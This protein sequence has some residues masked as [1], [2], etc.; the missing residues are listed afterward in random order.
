MNDLAQRISKL[1]PQQRERLLKK[2]D[3]QVEP[4]AAR[5]TPQALTGPVPLSFAQERL[6]FLQQ[7]E[8][9]NTFYNII[10]ALCLDGA[11]DRAAL[12]AAFEEI[13]RRHDALRTTFPADG[14][15]PWQHIAPPGP[16]AIPLV[17]LSGLP[18]E[19]REAEV[20]RW[21]R[22]EAD[23]PFKLAEEPLVRI[24]LFYLGG[25]THVLLLN[26][27][28]I[29]FDGW[30]IGVLIE[31]FTA[32][33][34]AFRAGRPSPLP[35]LPIQ[36]ADYSVWQRGHLSGATLAGHLDYWRRQLHG[37]P[38]LLTLPT[39]RPRPA[40]QSYRGGTHFFQ[41]PKA[42]AEPLY[43]LCR[44]E[45]ATLFMLLLAAFQLLLSRH[46]GQSDICVG[47]PIANRSR[48][49]LEGLI[50]FFVNTMVLRTDLSGN[51]T[52]TELLG[53]VR[54]VCLGAQVH[55]DL[56]FEKLV[57]ELS[58]VRD[59]GH[60][61]LFQAVLVL[62]NAPSRELE[63]AG[64]R[65]QGL[66]AETQTAKFDL[67]LVLREGEKGLD[68]V[69]ETG[70]AL[71]AAIEYAT[72]L[73]DPPTVARL[74][75]HFQNL[76]AG[77]AARPEARLSELPM[78]AESER[79]QL[80]EE[81][82]PPAPAFPEGPCLHALFEAQAARTPQAVALV[83]GEESLTY[84][85]LNARAN[86]LAWRLRALG[87][88]PESLVGLCAERS[89][90][91]VA[92]L[93][94]ILKAGGAYLPLDPDYPPERLAFMLDDARPR[95]L[96]AHSALA[97]R[98]PPHPRTLP[99]DG[100]WP[101][102]SA[103]NPP[104]LAAPGNLAYVIYTSGSTGRPK[105]VGVTH[106]NVRRLFSATEAACRFSADDVWT[107]FHS[108]AFDFS[109]WE[110]WGALLYG[111]RA[112]V[113]PYWASRSPEA[114]RRLLHEQ[115]VTVFSQ[116]PSSFYQVD[117]ADAERAGSAPL[118]LKRVVFGGEALDAR[119]LAGWFARHGAGGPE[120]VNM[121]G[122]TETTVHVT[123]QSLGPDGP[124]G[125]IGRPLADLQTH[126]LDSRGGLVPVGVAGEICVG[127]AGLARGYLNRPGL[128]AERFVPDPFGPPGGRLYR[129]GDLARRRPDGGLYYLGRIDH[130]V[131]IRG[132]RIELGE[133]EARLREHPGVKDA[134]VLAGEGQGGDAR[135]VAYLVPAL[136]EGPALEAAASL[137]GEQ[138]AQW[139]TVF[140]EAFG[141]QAAA[142]EDPTFRIVGW[143]SSYTS[144]PFPP[145]EMREWVEATVT[146]IAAF[147]PRRLLEIGCGM[148][149][150][151]FRLAPLVRGVHRHRLFRL[152]AGP[153]QKRLGRSPVRDSASDAA[154]TA[155]RRFFRLRRGRLR[156]RGVELR[157]PV[158]PRPGLFPVGAAR[159]DPSHRAGRPDRRRRRAQPGFGEAVPCRRRMGRR[160]RRTEPP[161]GA[162]AREPAL[163]ARGGA[164]AASAV[165]RLAGA[166]LPQSQPRRGAAEAWRLRQRDEPV[167]LRRRD[168]CR[169]GR[170]GAGRRT[171][172]GLGRA[173]RQR[174]GFASAPFRGAA[175]AV[176]AQ[177]RA[178]CEAGRRR[179]RRA[180][181]GPR[182]RLGPALGGGLAAGRRGRA[183]GGHLAAGGVLAVPLRVELAARRGG[184]RL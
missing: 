67:Q 174:G 50:G 164:A 150:L 119:R 36:Y 181:A 43:E 24:H 60:N 184:R 118:A 159:R 78:L 103:A 2:L 27:H 44:R 123:W 65:L 80:L 40:V 170:R 146:R 62:Q 145:E 161:R 177:G 68:F 87:V 165:V 54:A 26:M 129:S 5:I 113:V 14:G 160:V 102:E 63:V 122:I 55:Q 125:A 8:P 96:L 120:L 128:T 142:D 124:A 64:L 70:G 97:G 101:E 18:S 151:L 108:Y 47:S 140:D 143:N 10:N 9:D 93:L 139:Q 180:G 46:S 52:F 138:I 110:L 75:G 132:F 7:L 157:G 42:V 112:V 152:G 169:R 153:C 133:I 81:W 82:N 25:D 99:L 136:D 83:C 37:A 176:A 66:G 22:Q 35:A 79:R 4:A 111:G 76:L 13:L 23:R 59:M 15:Q 116:T 117:A 12:A 107:V 33:Y 86:R 6:W 48:I 168:P 100:D 162:G 183:S 156:H 49:E 171:M 149:L 182:R 144:K 126:L 134:A 89:L 173:D 20:E 158:F 178:E 104:P 77:I 115:R 16:L 72:D 135:L 130:Q 109:V 147:Q 56:P 95:A 34:A 141:P 39:D 154:S 85:G 11:L 45:G 21:I 105:G 71:D 91:M 30:S 69:T 19:W 106:Q 58:P 1:D 179:R 175:G 155:G 94:A 31:E 51:P 17:D 61:P 28:H 163:D 137:T 90:E 38:P 98:L 172:A 3:R 121:Y 29:V 166:L 131:K 167:P 84:A 127:G 57:E 88:G 53:R 73:F 74:A 114:V 32:L 41:V 92:G 148:G